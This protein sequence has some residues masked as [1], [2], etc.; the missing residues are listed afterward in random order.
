MTSVQRRRSATGAATVELRAARLDDVEEIAAV[1]AAGWADAHLG[2][3]SPQVVAVRTAAS[4]EL[5]A[6]E[7]IPSTTVA[8]DGGEVVGFVTV[9]GDEVE[10]LYV[11]APFRG[12]GVADALLTDAEH[13]IATA[14]YR[15]A[16]LA[17]V[18]GNLRARW[19]YERMGWI[20][21]GPI[22]Y[23]AQGDGG[24]IAVPAERYAK[25][26]A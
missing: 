11:A 23:P 3:V 20:D 1:W 8:A 2:N 14:G 26:L 6:A 7:R 10:Q 9:V 18:V 12:R 4:F 25:V 17:V 5:R 19:F 13:Q 16:W 15:C 24:A 22:E 21:E